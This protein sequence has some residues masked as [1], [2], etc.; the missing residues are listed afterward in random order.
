MS[1]LICSAV[2]VSMTF[3]GKTTPTTTDT[4]SK[5]NSSEIP[6]TTA[7]ATTEAVEETTVEE[8]TIEEITEAVNTTNGFAGLAEEDKATYYAEHV[9]ELGDNLKNKSL[10]MIAEEDEMSMDIVF[11]LTEDSIDYMSMII[12]GNT[13]DLVTLGEDY[14]VRTVFGD[15]EEAKESWS[16]A[17]VTNKESQEEL[18]SEAGGFEQLTDDEYYD[19]AKYVENKDIDGKNYDIVEFV[20][21]TPVENDEDIETASESSEIKAEDDYSLETMT[22]LIN[23]ETG[24]IERIENSDI[25]ESEDVQIYVE[26]PVDTKELIEGATNIEEVDEETLMENYMNGMMSLIFGGMDFSVEEDEN[27]ESVEETETVGESVEET[28]EETAEETVEET[29]GESVEETVEETKSAL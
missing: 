8:T 20:V 6:V 2:L 18:S 5:A 28:A 15:G 12:N 19:S 7:E 13:L 23:T 21:K 3:C 25:A 14:Y 4:E 16:H 24:N 9:K 10:R 29:V 11:N 27:V 17:K 1:V 22:F 26:D